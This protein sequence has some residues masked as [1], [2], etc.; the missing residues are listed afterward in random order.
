M[1]EKDKEPLLGYTG[2]FRRPNYK[3]YREEWVR[4]LRYDYR[5]TLAPDRL[6]EFW[7]R[8]ENG[9]PRDEGKGSWLAD[10]SALPNWGLLSSYFNVG[11]AL[12]LGA[13]P[14]SYYL[15]EK[16]DASA[17][18]VNTYGALTYLPWSLKFF[19][20]TQSDLVPF[21]GMH[22]R[23]YYVL[24]W[25][26]YARAAKESEIPNFKASYL[27]RFPLVSANSWTSD[28]LSERSRSMDAL[29]GTRARGTLTLKRR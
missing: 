27:G 12:M 17:A 8:D 23:S 4:W 3:F 25:A 7:F 13:T 10:L 2:A 9:S 14:I 6:D 18:V 29:S 11:V 26:V 28:H 1:A 24:G 22:R 15:V 16:L 21:L 5:T 19:Y 20:G